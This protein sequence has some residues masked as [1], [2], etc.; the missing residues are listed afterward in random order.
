MKWYPGLKKFETPDELEPEY[1][2]LLVHL[3]SIQADIGCAAVQQL[4]PWL[5]QAPSVEDRWILARILNEEMRH[6]WQ[7]CRLLSELDEEELVQEILDRKEGSHKLDAF[8]LPLETWP[9]CVGYIFFV[10]RAGLNYL[11]DFADCS[12]APLDRAVEMMIREEKLHS[13]FGIHRMRAFCEDGELRKEAEAAARKWYPRALDCFGR[14]ASR[15]TELALQFGIRKT[16]NE[17][18]RQQYT[19]EVR[20]V[21]GRW[22]LELPD[23]AWDRKIL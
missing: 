1:Q 12:Y 17:D 20:E 19:K 16:S 5:D 3:I 2:D 15:A 13:D 7:M 6:G 22:G 10:E 9:D 8:N 11:T 21:T 18:L 23:E 14:K 4:R